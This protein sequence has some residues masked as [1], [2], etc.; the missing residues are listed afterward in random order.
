MKFELRID[1]LVQED[2][3]SAYHHFE[4]LQ[5]G[6]GTVFLAALSDMLD[7][8]EGHPNMYQKVKGDIRRGLIRRFQYAVFYRILSEQQI[9]VLAIQQTSR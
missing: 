8:I 1:P 9:L 4:A 2:V 3:E 6:L 7:K 5:A